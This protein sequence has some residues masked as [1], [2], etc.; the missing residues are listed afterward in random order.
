M[1]TELRQRKLE[2]AYGSIDVDQDGVI[3]AL[4]VTALAQIWCETYD[5]PPRSADWFAIH[6]AGQKLFREMPGSTGPDGVKHVTAADWVRWGDDARFPEFVEN[7][8]IPF[9][10]A[11]FDAADKDDDGKIDR[12]EMMAAQIRGGMSEVE[13]KQAFGILDTDGDGYVTHDEYVR[14][15]RDFYLSDDPEA[16]GN[17]IAGEL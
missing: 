6:A 7:T 9:S 2:K 10:M 4:D 16:P 17:S 1:T 14:A 15:A 13:T 8:A 12:A 3:T 5:L 11:V